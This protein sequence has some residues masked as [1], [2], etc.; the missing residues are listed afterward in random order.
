MDAFPF[1]QR[2]LL[3]QWSD[4]EEIS[5]PTQK[6]AHKTYPNSLRVL[7]DLLVFENYQNESK[8]VKEEKNRS[9]EE[10]YL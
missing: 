9:V 2:P 10:V 1:E 6:V 4:L 8:L 3:P 7:I 5:V